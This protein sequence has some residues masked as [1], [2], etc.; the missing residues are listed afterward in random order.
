MNH[1]SERETNDIQEYFFPE[2]VQ[3]FIFGRDF[4][5][6]SRRSRAE[7]KVDNE[8]RIIPGAPSFIARMAI[9]VMMFKIFR[10]TVQYFAD[11]I[12]NVLFT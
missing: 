1:S 11:L 12:V 9:Q 5:N 10:A 4:R 8:G 2:M 3:T 7:D 6:E